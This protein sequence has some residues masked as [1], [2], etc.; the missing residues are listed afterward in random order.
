MKTIHRLHYF[1]LVLFSGITLQSCEEADTVLS[2]PVSTPATVQF[3][4]TN[5]GLS[6]LATATEVTLQLSH[7]APAAGTITININLENEND[8]TSQPAVED[9]R[10]ILPVA[11]GQLQ[12]KFILT[13]TDNNLYTGNR[14]L[15]FTIGSVT[16][17]L[18]IGTE[19]SLHVTIFENEQPNLVN[20]EATE[21]SLQEQFTEGMIV[22][23]GLS[24]QAVDAGEVELELV[25]ATGLYGTYFTTEP[26]AI[27]GKITMP[28]AAGTSSLPI[29]FIPVN[30]LT[31]NGHREF[32]VRIIDASGS[33]MK[34][35][36]LELNITLIDDELAG[37]PKSYETG[38]GEWKTKRVYEYNESG[39]IARIHVEQNSLSWTETYHYDENNLLKKITKW[40]TDETIFKRD[41]QNRI[42]RSEESREGVMKKYSIYSYDQAGNIGEVAVFHRQPTGE[43]VMSNL[44]VYLYY[45]NSNTVFK[46]LIYYPLP[47]D[48][49]ALIQ[50]ETF[51]YLA[52]NYTQNPFPMVDILP[53][54]NS[55]PLYP[56]K[57]TL[58]RDG[59]VYTY[60]L[61]YE[62]NPVGYPVSRTIGSREATRY[63]YY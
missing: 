11:V 3:V 59:K 57:Y 21:G 39:Q 15:L 6:E 27:N 48:E 52:S 31:L 13:P 38:A 51:E 60:Y 28:V 4:S 62:F 30:N 56:S 49:Y 34:G 23:L 1:L 24:L 35:D 8:F 50:E 18:L 19:K 26:E 14:N 53:G 55:Q 16:T 17:G 58:S 10:I 12:V 2:N 5:I 47:G 45:S 43:F 22:T 44:F 41:N 46:K 40:T 61:S 54:V 32:V 9:G 63:Q 20:F 25:N 33:V 36:M 37:K 29:K 7:P 42:T